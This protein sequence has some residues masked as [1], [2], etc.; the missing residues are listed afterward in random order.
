MLVIAWV[1]TGNNEKDRMKHWMRPA[2]AMLAVAWGGNEFTPLLVMYRTQHHLPQVTVNVLLFAYVL[3]IIPALLIGGPLSD[4]YGRR[5]LLVPA[6]YIAMLASAVLAFAPPT[7]ARDE[8][9]GSRR[10]HACTRSRQD[11][12]SARPTTAHRCRPHPCT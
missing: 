8:R 6:P 2:L 4:R 3:G 10:P 5:R 9:R 12:C 1:L 7:S 11:M